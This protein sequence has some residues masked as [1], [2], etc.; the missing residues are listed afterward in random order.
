MC[1]MGLTGAL[2][3][4]SGTWA[5][6]SALT[7]VCMVFLAYFAT[8]TYMTVPDVRNYTLQDAERLLH[9]RGYIPVVFGLYP[10]DPSSAKVHDQDKIGFAIFRDVELVLVSGVKKQI[11]QQDPHI[12]DR[13]DINDHLIANYPLDNS[14][15]DRSQTNPPMRLQNTEFR[16]DS[17]YLNGKYQYD[18]EGGYVAIAELNRFNYNEFTFS[19]D[20]YSCEF[21]DQSTD[22][23]RNLRTNILTGGIS[24]R[25]F[26]IGWNN[27]LLELTFNNQRW[28]RSTPSLTLRSQEWYRVILSL[29]LLAPLKQAIVML[30]K[31]ESTPSD[32]KWKDINLEDSFLLNV[33]SDN[34]GSRDKSVTFTNYSNGNTFYGLVR[35]LQVYRR[36]LS[37]DQMRSLNYEFPRVQD[38]DTLCR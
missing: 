5:A 23:I 26:A 18:D 36:A 7:S 20:F 13:G 30:G 12:I 11:E 8:I 9:N 31:P 27:G 19:L 35:N 33:V 38:P 10:D 21:T 17:L 34:V 25:W 37:P 15:L 16:E 24:Y 4:L 6:I 14:S 28:R 22:D 2:N 1:V 29:N 32:W 3:Q